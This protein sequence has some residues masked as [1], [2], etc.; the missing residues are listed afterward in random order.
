M[1][2]DSKKEQLELETKVEALK[3]EA[4]RLQLE[5]DVLNYDIRLIL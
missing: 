4:Y 1:L 2:Y 5:N 3:K